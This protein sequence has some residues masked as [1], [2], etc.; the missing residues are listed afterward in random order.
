MLWRPGRR[1]AG[2]AAQDLKARFVHP[3]ETGCDILQ[4]GWEERETIPIWLQLI[5]IYKADTYFEGEQL[6]VHARAR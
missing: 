2:A 5:E 3:Q 6:D 1:A 4:V